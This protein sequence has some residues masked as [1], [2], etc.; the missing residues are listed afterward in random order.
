MPSALEKEFE[1]VDETEMV[2]PIARIYPPN[3]PIKVRRADFHEFKR[4]ERNFANHGPARNNAATARRFKQRAQRPEL[5]E[6]A[7]DAIIR[8]SDN[9]KRLGLPISDA[10]QR[11][12]EWYYEEVERY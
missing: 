3:A 8:A 12:D 6:V 4:R 1:F 9:A 7:R 5:R 10:V 11:F 2:F